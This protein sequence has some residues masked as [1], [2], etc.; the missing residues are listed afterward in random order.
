M[1]QLMLKKLRMLARI[2]MKDCYIIEKKSGL[3]NKFKVTGIKNVNF[4]RR[5]FKGI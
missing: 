3:P 2:G 4:R 1:K 5:T